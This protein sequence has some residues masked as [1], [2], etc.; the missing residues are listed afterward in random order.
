MSQS[1]S[2]VAPTST[3]DIVIIGGGGHVGLPLAIAFAD[4]GARVLISDTSA[5]AVASV[6][7]GRMPFLERD[8]EPKLRRALESSRLFATTDPAAAGL[9]DTIV[10]VIGTS[11]DE[12]LNPDPH[13]IPRALAQASEH[14]RDGQLVIL[15]STVFPGVTRLV[16]RTFADHGLKVD[17]AF[18]PSASP[19]ATRWSSCSPCPS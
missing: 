14:M 8:A 2:Q 6:N 5:A 1:P 19:R 4:R 12:H 17:V 18:C 7:A 3:W 16:E 10:V 15:R 11:V 9:A 13:A